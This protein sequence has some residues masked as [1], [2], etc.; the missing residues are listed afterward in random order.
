MEN[1]VDIHVVR[2]L[3]KIRKI[4]SDAVRFYEYD[5]N[6]KQHLLSITLQNLKRIS[7]VISEKTYN[8]LKEAIEALL[9]IK[10]DRQQARAYVAPRVNMNGDFSPLLLQNL[11][12]IFNEFL[13]IE[14]F[15]ISFCLMLLTCSNL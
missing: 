11:F 2:T 14:Y 12:E 1:R 6:V 15:G 8:Q 9:L 5:G 7:T 10:N 4:L 13:T 3:R